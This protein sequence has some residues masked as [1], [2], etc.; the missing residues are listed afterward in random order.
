MPN[1]MYALLILLWICSLNDNFSSNHT[2][3]II[4]SPFMRHCFFPAIA[5]SVYGRRIGI[6][7]WAIHVIIKYVSSLEFLLTIA[8]LQATW[9]SSSST[10]SACE[11]KRMF[12]S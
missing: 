4:L 7:G 8:T 3:Q 10:S 2:V 12:A 11:S 6:W 9:R 1:I 5:A